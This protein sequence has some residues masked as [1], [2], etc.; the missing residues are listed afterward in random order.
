MGILK[1]LIMMKGWFLSGCC[2]EDSGRTSSW[3]DRS[4]YIFVDQ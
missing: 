1:T 4:S 3:I 2:F